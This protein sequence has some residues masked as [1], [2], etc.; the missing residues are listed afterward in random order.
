MITEEQRQHYLSFS[1]NDR[2]LQ[3]YIDVLV[4]EKAKDDIL[5]WQDIA[6][7]VEEAYDYTKSRH[8]YYRNYGSYYDTLRD[9]FLHGEDKEEE[10]VDTVDT[11]SFQS[12]LLELQKEK[13]KISDERTQTRAYIRR[14][15]REDT[16]KEIALQAVEN[17]SAKKLLPT[18][19]KSKTAISTNRENEAIVLLGDWHYGFDFEL[20]W[21]KFNPEICR[22][23]VAKLLNE[24]I[25]YCNRNDV[26]RIHVFNL[27]DLIA[28]RIHLT[29]RLES[30]IDTITQTM[31]V[32]EILSEFLNDLTEDFEVEY[33]SCI[34]NHSRLEP[35]KAD[36]LDLE[37]LCRIT[38]WYLNSRLGDRVTF[39]ENKYGL[40]IITTNILGH[41]VAGVHGHLDKPQKCIEDI[42]L[43][44]RQSYD[45]ICMAHLH[46][47]SMDEKSGCRVIGNGALMGTDGFA[48]NLRLHSKPS[49]TIVIVSKRRVCEDIHIVE[50]D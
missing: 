32:S 3:S 9:D 48:S 17:M 15:A 7:L 20:P 36:S 12:K 5:G 6:D 16:L 19:T 24:T 39:H 1:D 2:S 25:E 30:R 29:I 8:W 28:G 14:L 38:D 47:F 44:T 23:R 46:H 13:V 43:I 26:R 41:N 11:D 34:D 27:S 50:L 22:E 33:Y 42:S 4:E 21:N 40:D 18:Y 31:E 45:L 49:Q 35:N 10:T 37:S